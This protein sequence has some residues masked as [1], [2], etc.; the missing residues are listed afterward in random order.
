[1]ASRLSEDGLRAAYETG[2]QALIVKPE[3]AL[4]L[5]APTEV[6]LD[7]LLNAE[8][9]EVAV[10]AVPAHRLHSALRSRGIESAIDILPLLSTEQVTRM[11]DYEAWDGDALDPV[12]AF[13]WLAL[14]KEI[15]PDEYATRFKSLE[16]ELQLALVG[17][18]VKLIE[19]DEFEKLGTGDQD[20][21]R[22]LPSNDLYY[23]V[24]SEDPRID[25]AIEGIV[26]SMLGVDINYCYALLAHAA[27]MPPA[28]QE[29]MAAQF[30]Q[31]RLEEDGFVTY[32]ESLTTFVP[33]PPSELEGKR[34]KPLDAQALATTDLDHE[35]SFLVSAMRRGLEHWTAEEFEIVTQGF[36]FLANSLAAAAKIEPDDVHGMKRI[37]AH[38]QSIAGLGLEELAGGDLNIAAEVLRNEHPKILFRAGL[39]ELNVLQGETIEHLKSARVPGADA[40]ERL[41]RLARPGAVL[42]RL[43]HDVLPVLGFERTEVLKGLFNRFPVR[44]VETV[45][46]DGPK[47]TVFSPIASRAGLHVFRAAVGGLHGLLHLA[48]IAGEGVLPLVD[49]DRLLATSMARSLIGE[50]FDYEPLTEDELKRLLELDQEAAQQRSTEL[51]TGIEGTLVVAL[52]TTGREALADLSDLLMRLHTAREHDKKSG[53]TAGGALLA[54]VDAQ[55]APNEGLA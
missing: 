48:K 28:E 24:R 7:A 45:F 50:S 5:I 11:V 22:M 23:K 46:G 41:W 17:P 55:T 12:H 14:F 42:A 51:F 1:M 4:A 36:A 26:S 33:L 3:A 30:R 44:P 31:A 27:A 49:L 13:A 39:T 20:E 6:D 32:A 47:R 16:E 52:P 29:A 18:F 15:G 37:L 34:R 25:E 9:P 53:R 21:Y 54:L 2:H 19:E 38:A 35:P 10:Q 40:I 43:D 8:D